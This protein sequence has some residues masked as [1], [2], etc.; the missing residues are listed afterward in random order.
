MDSDGDGCPDHEDPEPFSSPQF[1]IVDCEN[2][3]PEAL[4]TTLASST[5]LPEQQVI[6]RLTELILGGG[7][8]GGMGEWFLPSIHFD[9]NRS[10]IRPDNY[11]E[12]KNIADLMKKSPSLKVNVYGHCDTRGSEKLNM[13]LSTKRAQAAVDHIAKKYGIDPSRFNSHQMG[14]SAPIYEGART[15]PQ[16]QA[17]RRVEFSVAS[18]DSP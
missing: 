14:K 16:H 3:L 8:G 15:E 13:D 6:D 7:G 5:K 9:L 10:E 1:P 4:Q 12:L 2:V 11:D 18:L 17:N